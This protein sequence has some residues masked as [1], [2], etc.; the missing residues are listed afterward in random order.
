[1]HHAL[2]KLQ[3]ISR[4]LG[5]RR[6][7][8]R[9]RRL[10]AGVTLALRAWRQAVQAAHQPMKPIL[11]PPR[12]AAI[13]A[14]QGVEKRRR[15]QVTKHQRHIAKI[16]LRRGARNQLVVLATHPAGIDH[17]LIFLLKGYPEGR[18]DSEIA[19]LIGDVRHECLWVP[20]RGYDV[21]TYW[22]LVR[23]GAFDYYCFLNSFSEILAPD[24]LAKIHANVS[25]DGIGIAGATGSWESLYQDLLDAAEGIVHHRGMA[26][27]FHPRNA[28]N[29]LRLMAKSGFRRAQFDA[30]PNPH[31]R[32]NAFMVSSSIA[33]QLRIGKVRSKENAWKLE[34][35]RRGITSQ[36][37]AMGKQAIVVDKEGVGYEWKRWADSK[38]FWQGRQE[39]L[40]VADNQTRRYQ[41]ATAQQQQKLARLA[42]GAGQVDK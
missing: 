8:W 14:L 9:R 25:K 29:W 5:L 24:W 23:R 1:M 42:W 41:E 17:D 30:F 15:G 37:V 21:E 28:L 4:V 33:R 38:T 34:S 18:L 20:D 2:D 36:I 35:G 16:R 13:D 26:G 7:A 32:S 40:L 10:H 39:S 22:L 3:F 6:N 31:L 27:A 19:S 12:L 11:K